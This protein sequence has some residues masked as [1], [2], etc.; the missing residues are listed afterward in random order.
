MHPLRIRHFATAMLVVFL[1][2]LG[3][4]SF[5]VQRM[6]HEWEHAGHPLHAATADHGE[7]HHHDA[8]DAATGAATTSDADHKLLHGIGLLQPGPLATF[9]WQPATLAGA[10]PAAVI[11]PKVAHATRE[12]PFRP[13]RTLI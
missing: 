9:L 12:P 11:P 1:T 2:S 13:P 6:A 10:I 7:H 3:A 4:W 8:D 5:N